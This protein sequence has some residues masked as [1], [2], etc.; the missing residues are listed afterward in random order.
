MD[1]KIEIDVE[2]WLQ[3]LLMQCANKRSKQNLI[4]YIS[5]ESGVAPDKVEETLQ[6]LARTLIDLT[7]SN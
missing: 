3:V 1:E 7:R 4:Q 6:V 5:R 2:M